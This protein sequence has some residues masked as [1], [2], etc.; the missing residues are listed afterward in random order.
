MR[1]LVKNDVLEVNGGFSYVLITG[2]DQNFYKGLELD[3]I[4]YNLFNELGREV[5]ILKKDLEKAKHF[6]TGVISLE[7]IKRM[8]EELN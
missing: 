6:Y 5:L 7:E 3:V 1:E 2:E 8:Y 4:E